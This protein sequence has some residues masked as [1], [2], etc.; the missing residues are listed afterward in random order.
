M[1][2]TTVAALAAVMAFLMAAPAWGDGF[3]SSFEPSDPAPTWVSTAERA[4]GVTGPKKSGIPGNVTD[5]VVSVTASGENTGGGEVKENLFDGSSDTKWL[6]FA[7]TGWV[8]AE[9]AQPVAVVDYAL[10]SANDAPGRDPRDWTLQGSQDGQ[11]WTTLDT[12]TGQDFSERFQTKEYRFAN[13]TAY[14]FYRLNVTANHG[15]GIVQLAELQ[16]SNGQPTPPPAPRWR[17]RWG[18]GRRA[19][20]TPS[21]APAG[22][23][24]TRCATP[25]STRR[26]GAATPTT[27]STTST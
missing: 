3:A 25:A 19:A 12:Q 24:C 14:R 11:T 7:S 8:A 27:R 4:G 23:A 13:S 26:P 16:L 22:R 20:T 2:R 17:R 21:R 1:K 5:T 15:D 9:L 18:A 6:V 10:T